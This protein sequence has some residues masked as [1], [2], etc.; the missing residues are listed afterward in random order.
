MA[1][2]EA[3]PED[4]LGIQ[5]R[6][7]RKQLEELQAG[8]KGSSRVVLEFGN[9][10]KIAKGKTSYTTFVKTPIVEGGPKNSK[11]P[12]AKVDFNINPGYAKPT[13][14]VSNP[15]VKTGALF[16]YT[17][18]R[19]YPCFVTVHFRPEW[20][21]P[22][23]TIEYVVQD[24]AMTKRRI[25][26][27]MP[28]TALGCKRP[29]QATFDGCPPR[30]G[31]IRCAAGISPLVLYGEAA[32]V[33][34]ASRAAAKKKAANSSRGNE[35]ARAAARTTSSAA[36]PSEALLEAPPSSPS[37]LRRITSGRMKE[38]LRRLNVDGDGMVDAVALRGLLTGANGSR[39]ELSE[40]DA[41]K[42]IDAAGVGPD[43][44]VSFD[45]FVDFVY[46]LDWEPEIS[47]KK[48]I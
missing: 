48:S 12:I 37:P 22:Q 42:V 30:N 41:Q 5:L 10:A 26:V 31:W 20:G 24:E 34:A 35:A 9:S 19:S 16:E 21:L 28:T 1:A 7:K 18:G 36:A 2:R 44:R 4:E 13:A 46:G 3:N 43:G 15:D 14:T 47:S 23:V 8:R 45:R 25:V 6:A 11:G 32:A 29:G 27:D 38:Q 39:F 17:M 40:A 33:P